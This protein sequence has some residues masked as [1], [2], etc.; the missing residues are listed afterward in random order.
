MKYRTKLYISLVCVALSSIILGLVIFSTQTEKLVLGMLKSRLLSVVATGANCINPNFFYPDPNLSMNSE[1]YKRARDALLKI[2]NANRRNDIY[3]SDVYTL[4]PDPGNPQ[5]LVIGIDSDIDPSPPG[6]SYVY[7]DEDLILKNIRTYFVDPGFYGDILGIWL[8]A[9]APILDA[10][11]KYVATLGVDIN[12]TDIQKKLEDLIKFALWGLSASLVFALILAFFLAKQVTTSLD[13]ICNIVKE[14]ELG[15]LEVQAKIYTNDEFGELGKRINA[16]AKGLQERERLKLSFA[17]YVSKHVLDKILLSE[18]PLKLEGERR[19]VTLLFSDLRQFTLL[20]E[21]LPPEAVVKILNEYFEQM[22]EVIFS[23]SGTLDKFIG[24]GIMAEFGVPLDDKEQE[25]HAVSA[26]IQMQ[27][28]MNKLCE[29]WVKENKPAIQMGVGIHTGDAVVGNVGSEKRI[30]YTAIGDTV[31]VA[32][33]LE[34]AT[35]ILKKPIL[36]SETTYLGC[37]DRFPFKD[38]GNMALPG[39]REQIK[40]YTLDWDILDHGKSTETKG[41]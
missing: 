32:A 11:G 18:T 16:M 17:R 26:A 2:Q 30:E 22:I 4:Y 29:K 24:D 34:Q 10:Q 12:A 13:Y 14:I 9:F 25:Y 33:R 15:N 8:S 37:K 20:A 40:V 5:K 23:H 21:A 19:K 41:T 3:L 27:K 7:R 35:K 31:N 38:L 28:E 39:R 1:E 6:S 36:L